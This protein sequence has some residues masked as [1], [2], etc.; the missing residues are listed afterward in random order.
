VSCSIIIPQT[1]SN[2][3]PAGAPGTPKENGIGRNGSPVLRSRIPLKVYDSQY[4]SDTEDDEPH[5]HH[6]SLESFSSN[7]STSSF[8]EHTLQYI[9]THNPVDPRVYRVLRNAIVRALTSEQLP[10]GQTSGKIL[11]GDP[12]HGYTI[13]YKFR[14]PDPYARGGHR[15]YS[16]LGLAGHETDVA[17]RT[18]P[19]LWG[20]FDEIAA[21]LLAKT[22]AT[23]RR[24]RQVE[25]EASEKLSYVPVS[26]FLTGRAMDPDGYPRR[27][28]GN[29]TRARGLTEIVG[30]PSF[31][32]KL[33]LKFVELLQALR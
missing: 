19:I 28:G 2:R 8:H 25:E 9:T 21:W 6:L 18:G 32:A 27:N 17:F 14:L 26:S 29:A 16:L 23:I 13:T 4:D 1:L 33:H 22:E 11:F 7:T 3:L 20:F 5:P 15:Q 31:F 30:D 10:R 24:N 12:I